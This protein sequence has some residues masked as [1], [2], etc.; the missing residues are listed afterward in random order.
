MPKIVLSIQLWLEDIWEFIWFYILKIFL[1]KINYYFLFQI[2]FFDVFQ[3][4]WCVHVK[5]KKYVLITSKFFFEK[6]P[7][8]QS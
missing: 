4:F 5:N 2:N 8:L 1:K 7:L 6:Q 3:L